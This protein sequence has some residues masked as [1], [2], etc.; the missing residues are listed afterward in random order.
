MNN[1]SGYVLNRQQNEMSNRKL[2]I[3]SISIDN[4]LDVQQAHSKTS[5]QPTFI[6][7]YS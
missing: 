3:N 2:S 5:H 6:S 7:L 4:E 1:A